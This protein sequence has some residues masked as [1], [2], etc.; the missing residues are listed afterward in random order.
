MAPVSKMTNALVEIG[1]ISVTVVLGLIG[2]PIWV[3]AMM[4]GV[5]SAWWVIVH[6]KRFAAMLATAAGKAIGSVLVALLVMV[7][8][9][10]IAYGVGGA[11][12]SI[13]GLK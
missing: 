1:L 13:L 4:V 5:S 12:H 3:V 11:F 2:L 8:A 10:L 7:F 6:H 9:H